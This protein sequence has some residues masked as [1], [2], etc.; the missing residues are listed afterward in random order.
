MPVLHIPIFNKIEIFDNPIMSKYLRNRGDQFKKKS[1]IS[2]FSS[3]VS[4]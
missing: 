2:D 3:T 4:H 1:I